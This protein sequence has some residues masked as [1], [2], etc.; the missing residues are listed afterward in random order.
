MDRFITPI[1]RGLRRGYRCLIDWTEF[2]ESDLI[3]R[4]ECKQ[5]CRA[6]IAR[7]IREQDGDS[8]QN[9]TLSARQDLWLNQPEGCFE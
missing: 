5:Q 8:V 6:H 4:E 7:M 9:R 2:I 3:S 1:K